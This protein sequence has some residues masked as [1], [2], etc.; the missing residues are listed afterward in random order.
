[1]LFNRKERPRYHE[2]KKIPYDIPATYGAEYD[3]YDYFY[4]KVPSDTRKWSTWGYKCSSCGKYHK[5]NMVYTS[6]FHTMDGYDSLD[7]EECWLC[8]IK[9]Y[10]RK[11]IY[12]IKNQC[13]LI[14][15]TLELKKE[16]KQK[17][18]YIKCYRLAKAIYK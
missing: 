8:T 5:L 12:K 1:M 3:E 10:I 15:K 7:F 17:L 2:D 4:T 9:N 6:Y 13:K 11:P 14:K 18:H 16:C